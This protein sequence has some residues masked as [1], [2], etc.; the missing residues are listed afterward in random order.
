M[1]QYIADPCNQ[2]FGIERIDA[3]AVIVKVAR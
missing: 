3:H 2:T 1:V